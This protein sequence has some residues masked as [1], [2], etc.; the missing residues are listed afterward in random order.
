MNLPTWSNPHRKRQLDAAFS[1]PDYCKYY[2]IDIPD[3][4]ELVLKL[5]SG[6]RLTPTE[7]DRYGIY[8]ITISLIAQESPKFKNKPRTEREEM[9]DYQY[10]EILQGITTFNPTRG[11]SLF[12]Y[13]YRIAWTACCHYY[14]DKNKHYQQNKVIEQHC[15]EELNEYLEEFTDHKRRNINEQ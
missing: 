5:K 12:S 9:L 4:T 13:T 6:Q 11:S 10:Y 2:D 15:L 14:N 3:F 8:I 7:N 1:S